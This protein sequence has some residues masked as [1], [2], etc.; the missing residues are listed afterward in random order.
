MFYNKWDEFLSKLFFSW[1]GDLACIV[2]TESQNPACLAKTL[3]FQSYRAP[4]TFSE[5]D[6]LEK[7]CLKLKK[8]V[9]NA[10]IMDI[11]ILR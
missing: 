3:L 9:K 5:L 8:K 2:H 1:R 11:S 4:Y 7:V 10:V 6:R